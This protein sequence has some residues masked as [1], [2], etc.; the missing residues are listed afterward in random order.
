MNIFSDFTYKVI[1][2][3]DETTQNTTFFISFYS[4][5]SIFFLF[6]LP[7]Y[8]VKPFINNT[9]GPRSSP[10]SLPYTPRPTSPKSLRPP[11]RHLQDPSLKVEKLPA[12]TQHPKQ[13]YPTLPQAWYSPLLLQALES[14]SLWSMKAL[15]R[16]MDSEKA[17][18]S[19]TGELRA[20]IYF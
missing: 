3:N 20:I 19:R 18:D 17:G 13:P 7:C 15:C 9:S 11:S 10:H 14:S 16:P 5:P 4:L 6:Y 1:Y 12:A 2:R 8:C